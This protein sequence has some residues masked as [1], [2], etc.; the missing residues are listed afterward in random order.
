M[1]LSSPLPRKAHK[2]GG[3]ILGLFPAVES[4]GQYPA[5]EHIQSR[6]IQ[7][8]EFGFVHVSEGNTAGM[9]A[10]C[11]VRKLNSVIVTRL[12]DHPG[13]ISIIGFA[14]ADATGALIGDAVQ[15]LLGSIQQCAF[16]STKCR[17]EFSITIYELTLIAGY[18]PS[19]RF[20]VFKPEIQERKKTAMECGIPHLAKF[21]YQHGAEFDF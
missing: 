19:S 21:G 16:V 5:P 10:K 7:I 15:I 6:F 17:E 18:R 11:S 8:L 20:P 12:D 4:A 14:D 1:F 2:L 9:F 3:G 13:A